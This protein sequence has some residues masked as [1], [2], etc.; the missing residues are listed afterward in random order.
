MGFS[1]SGSLNFPRFLF[2]LA[3]V[4]CVA[5]PVDAARSE[6]SKDRLF[7][8][9]LRLYPEAEAQFR[10]RFPTADKKP[11]SRDQQAFLTRQAKN[12]ANRYLLNGSDAAV[13]GLLTYKR[14]VLRLMSR[15]PSYCRDFFSDDAF[16]EPAEFLASP[17]PAEGVYAAVLESAR[18][19]PSPPPNPLDKDKAF[20]MLKASYR[21]IGHD[22]ETI[23]VLADLKGQDR[24]EACRAATH[25]MEA[26]VAL[27]E[28]DGTYVYKSLI[29]PGPIPALDKPDAIGRL[30]QE[31]RFARLYNVL[32]RFYPEAETEMR[33]AL[34]KRSVQAGAP[35]LFE[36][37]GVVSGLL[38]DKHVTRQMPNASDSAIFGLV[39]YQWRML[40]LLSRSPANCVSYYTA[41]PSLWSHDIQVSG[42]LG[43]ADMQADILESA[44]TSPAPPPDPLDRA[45]AFR[46]VEQSYLKNG[47]DPA[48]SP[49]KSD[50]RTREFEVGCRAATEFYVALMALG[51]RDA[52]YVYKTLRMTE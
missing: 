51:E 31:Y 49:I 7:E 34:E 13:H 17:P 36:A 2:L 3:L 23:G 47:F 45:K 41:D 16:V 42:S 6:G 14:D 5:V 37:A 9:L 35:P 15:Y 20:G 50:I 33:A 38:V 25:Y 43:T 52:A 39:K 32:F 22:P 12:H 11:Y 44:R 26:L 46:M 48:I 18:A 10:T 40:R 29:M 30:M 19:N 27:G 8:V 4:L 1:G 24:A 28:T 21:A